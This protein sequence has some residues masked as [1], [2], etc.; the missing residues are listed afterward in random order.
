M[1]ENRDER[2][3]AAR[4]FEA[5][6]AAK[7]AYAD[8]HLTVFESDD[9]RALRCALTGVVIVDGDECVED[10][11]TSEVFLRSALSL[12]PRPLV[13]RRVDD[14]DQTMDDDDPDPDDEDA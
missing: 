5:I 14:T 3:E 7:K 2:E 11:E 1:I 12:P 8:Y 4:L 6:K 9:G 13:E 10:L